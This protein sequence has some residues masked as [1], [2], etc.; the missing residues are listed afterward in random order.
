MCFMLFF[1]KLLILIIS[2]YHL[3]PKNQECISQREEIKM[4]QR[5]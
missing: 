4:N 5:N 2:S 3:F 1:I